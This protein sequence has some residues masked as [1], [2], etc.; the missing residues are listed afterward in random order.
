MAIPNDTDKPLTTKQRRAVEY[1]AHDLLSD[2][3]IA[4][5]LHITKNT[6][7]RWKR[8]PAF[9]A[10]VVDAAAKLAEAIRA[11][12]IANKQN[13]IDS[14]RADYEL[15]EQIRVERAED[16]RGAKEPGLE[17]GLI[18]RTVKGLG[19][20]DNFQI[21]NEYGL[22]TALINSRNTI[23]EKIARE[24]GQITDKADVSGSV[25]VRLVGVNE[26]AL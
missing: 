7:E 4:S 8:L 18:I 13:R 19:A 16:A 14:Y 25:I 20:G 11:E 21:I 15:L 6:L 23:R 10:A 12:G 26:D 1:V 5:E 24:L 22:D 2:A 9:A 17:T 3:E